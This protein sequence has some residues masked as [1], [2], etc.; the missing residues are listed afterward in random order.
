VDQV[1]NGN[2]WRITAVD[3]DTNRI[4]AERLTDNARVVFDDDYLREHVTLGYAVTVHSAQGITTDTAHAVLADGATRAMAYVA[5]SRGRDT[6]EAYIYTRD[7]AEADHDHTSPTADGRFHQ[8][9]RGTKYSAAHH[10]RNIAS[11]DDRPRTM[12]VEAQQADCELL[13]NTIHELLDRHDHRLIARTEAWRQHAAAA[14][15]FRAAG[16]RMMSGADRTSD[17]SRAT[18]VGGLEL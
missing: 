16:E 4:A 10:L 8:L 2:R 5:M 1:R 17:R 6:N 11:N 18:D 12:H 3:A 9:R 14:R 7:T 13:P 15:D